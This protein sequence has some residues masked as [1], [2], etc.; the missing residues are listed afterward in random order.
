M[1]DQINELKSKA[2]LERIANLTANYEGEIAQLRAEAT[3]QFQRMQE[4]ID[5][6]SKDESDE[7]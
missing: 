1:T 3:V 4:Q 7:K 2:L 6:L 5:S